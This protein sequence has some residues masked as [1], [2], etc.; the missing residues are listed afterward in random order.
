MPTNGDTI[1]VTLETQLR[2]GISQAITGQRPAKQA[3]DSVASDWQ[4]TIRRSG[5]VR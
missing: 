2:S 4:R 1:W 5:T 3:L